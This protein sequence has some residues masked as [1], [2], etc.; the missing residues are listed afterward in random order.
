VP[1]RGGRNAV[2]ATLIALV[3]CHRDG[4]VAA[5]HCDAPRI[6]ESR[7]AAVVTNVL[8]AL[9]TTRVQHA[10]SIA[11]TYRAPGLNGVTPA[12]LPQ[13]DSTIVPVLGLLANT[14][15]EL[16]AVAYGRCATLDG[17]ALTFVT[18]ALPADLPLY[19]A[20]GSS[21]TDGFIV[22]AAGVYGLVIDNSGRV[23]WYHRF[24]GG[25]GL[26]FQAQPNGRYVARPPS[27]DPLAPWVEVDPT[28][29]VTRTLGCAHGLAPRFHDLLM[30][31][32]G[33]YWVMC[34]DTRVVNLTAMGGLPEA[35]VTGT[36]VQHIGASGDLLFEWSPFDHFAITDLA[37][38]ERRGASVNWTHGNAL[39]LDRDGNILVSFRSL[40]EITKIDSRTGDV[41]WRLGGLANQFSFADSAVPPFWGQHGLRVL[42]DGSLLLL[43]NLG[44]SS[45]SRAERYEIDQARRTA[46]L[47][48]SYSPDATVIAQLGGTTQP[49][50]SG[51]A[52]VSFGSG[53][54]VEEYAAGGASAWRIQ[55]NPGYVF[56]AQRIRSLYSPGVG[57][58]R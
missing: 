33:S 49:L 15:F 18:G 39:D 50:P 10:D 19:T 43:D 58:P 40:N 52:L 14:S 4:P 30:A 32:D 2:L 42:S 36:G 23:V 38:S 34:D 22:F 54:R 47:I 6:L 26:N 44:E 21:P 57:M 37:L 9:V 25:P 3:A 56:R 27:P 41:I 8:S 45:G 13:G 29:A 16:R 46:R 12:V 24:N 5:A 1:Q 28:G 20:G 35:R 7:A 48:R 31:P 51:G 55:G 53:G 11:V 17:P